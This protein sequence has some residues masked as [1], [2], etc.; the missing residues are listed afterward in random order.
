MKR[1]F[2][3]LLFLSAGIFTSLA[4]KS[5][6]GYTK[7]SDVEQR[8]IETAEEE[9]N[10]S[11]SRFLRVEYRVQETAEEEFHPFKAEQVF[12]RQIN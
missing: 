1:S 11:E 12:V 6:I 2:V 5:L 10:P 4:A 7:G 3:L 9:F 8:V